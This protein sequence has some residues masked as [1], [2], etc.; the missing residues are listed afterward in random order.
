MTDS[1][2]ATRV[3]VDTNIFVYAADPEAGD[4]LARCIGDVRRSRGHE[5]PVGRDRLSAGLR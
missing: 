5:A 1:I 3:L 2:A 4:K